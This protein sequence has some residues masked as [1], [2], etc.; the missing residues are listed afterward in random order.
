MHA[1]VRTHTI[2]PIWHTHQGKDKKQ[3][4]LELNMYVDKLMCTTTNTCM[5]RN[6]DTMHQHVVGPVTPRMT[7][8][9]LLDELDRGAILVQLDATKARVRFSKMSPLS[10]WKPSWMTKLGISSPPSTIK[11]MSKSWSHH[12][13]LSVSDVVL[14]LLKPFCLTWA[15]VHCNVTSCQVEFQV[16]TIECNGHRVVEES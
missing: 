1:I 9:M 7:M 13:N 14:G 5:E 12:N 3:V 16:S 15:H 11:R 10:A 4:Q 6:V 8:H 2:P